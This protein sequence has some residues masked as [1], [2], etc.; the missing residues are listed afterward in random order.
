MSAS[1]TRALPAWISPAILAAAAVYLARHWDD[2]PPRWVVH[3]GADG[4][5]NGWSAKSWESAAFPLLLGIGVWLVM[6]IVAAALRVQARAIG[7]EGATAGSLPFLRWISV[8]LSLMLAYLAI[9]L[10]LGNPE[11]GHSLKILAVFLIGSIVAG[12]VHGSLAF[13]QARREGEISMPTGYHGLYYANRE[14][15]R[16]FVPKLSGLGWT[17][18][19]SHPLAWPALL[20]IIALPFGLAL[21]IV[22]LSR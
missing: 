18:N 14:D 7:V 4:N 1:S 3:W 13:A 6:E 15:D 22:R 2:V 9:D 10:P 20:V 19:F 5:P 11:V 16:L 17:I 8:G 21:L 12:I